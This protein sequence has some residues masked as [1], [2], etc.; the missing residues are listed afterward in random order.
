MNRKATIT[1]LECD[2]ESEVEIVQEE[3]G[4]Y[5]E[6]PERCWNCGTEFDCYEVDDSRSERRQMGIT[7]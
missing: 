4:E 3:H 5:A 1:C 7:Y 2:Q 6:V